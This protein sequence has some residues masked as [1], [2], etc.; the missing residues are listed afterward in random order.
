MLLSTS[1]LPTVTGRAMVN[2]HWDLRQK[3]KGWVATTKTGHVVVRAETRA[4]AIKKA[5]RV[6]Q[7]LVGSRREPSVPERVLPARRPIRRVRPRS[8]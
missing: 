1:V 5:A 3:K 2:Q 7:E 8:M 4:E 6:T